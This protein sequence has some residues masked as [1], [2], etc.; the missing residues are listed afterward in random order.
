MRRVV[1]WLLLL[2][3]LSLAAST[4]VAIG[5]RFHD[6]PLGPIPGGP[7]HQAASDP[8]RLDPASVSSLKTV[9]IEVGEAQPLSRTTWVLVNDGVIYI[10]AG[11]AA[12]KQWPKQAE[13]AGR[14]R[15]RVGDQ[16]FAL[17]ATR[18]TDPGTIQALRKSVDEKYGTHAQQG[19]AMA[20]GT[21]FFR[22]EPPN[23]SSGMS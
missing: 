8:T 3:A 18:V 12:R 21:W 6:G 2:T 11:M 7:F 15:L 4:L 9:E 22:L 23:A 5:V 19:G 20:E 17:K 14:L 13:A 16:V 10:P 1:G